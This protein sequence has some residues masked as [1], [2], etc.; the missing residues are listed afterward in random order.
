[1]FMTT[2]MFPKTGGVSL[3]LPVCFH[4]QEEYLYDYQ[5]VSIYRRS[6]SMTTSMLALP[7]LMLSRRYTVPIINDET[8][9]TCNY[10]IYCCLCFSRCRLRMIRSWTKWTLWTILLV[11]T[12]FAILFFLPLFTFQYLIYRLVF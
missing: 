1:M 2:S 7:I 4:L 9:F 10:D 11:K 12:R 8:F 5:Y 3:W 6:M